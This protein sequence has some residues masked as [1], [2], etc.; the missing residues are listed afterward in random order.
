[1]TCITFAVV[2]E[3]KVSGC[4]TAKCIMNTDMHNV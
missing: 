1:M 2:G 4:P 3:C